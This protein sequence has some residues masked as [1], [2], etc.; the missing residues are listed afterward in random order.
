MSPSRLPIP[1][2]A[3]AAGSL[4]GLKKCLSRPLPWLA[5][6]WVPGI[7]LL[8]SQGL[9]VRGGGGHEEEKGWSQAGRGHPG[10][11][12]PGNHWL[13]PGILNHGN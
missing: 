4:Q 1:G 13:S 7:F 6:V 11:G 3:S 5:E 8:L 12:S 9:R 10:R 2:W